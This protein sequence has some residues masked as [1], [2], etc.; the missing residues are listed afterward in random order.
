MCKILRQ[1]I[2]FCSIFYVKMAENAKRT[3]TGVLYTNYYQCLRSLLLVHVR[4]NSGENCAADGMV[5][6]AD[7]ARHNAEGRFRVEC[8]VFRV[9][10]ECAGEDGCHAC[11]LHADFDGNG[12]L[13][14]GVELEQTTDA[15]AEHVTKAVMQKYYSED[16]CDKTKTVREKLWSHGHDDSAYDQCETDNAYGGHV[17]LEFLEACTLAEEVVAGEADCNRENRHVKDVEEHADGVH[18]DARVSKPKDQKRG[19]ERSE[20]CACHGHAHGVGHVAF[21]QKAHDVA[22]NATWAATDKDNADSQIRVK[23][24]ELSEREC[25]ERHDGV[26]CHGAKENVGGAFHQVANIVHGNSEAHAEHDDAE[27]N[28]TCV[29]VYPA[30]ERGNKKC[31]DRACD[32]KKRCVCR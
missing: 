29:A 14:G 26:L 8:E 27:N 24:K 17:C 21:C 30:K 13:L 22:R 9:R 16:E 6:A 7:G 12:A 19:H 5:S 11:I 23:S 32:D 18:F 2:F 1:N 3:S 10:E 15:V 20:K 4:K 25:N 28:R 31:D